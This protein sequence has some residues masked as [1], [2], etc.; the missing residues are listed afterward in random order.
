MTACEKCN[1]EC[2]RYVSVTLANPKGPEDWDEMKWI[3]LHN[4]VMIYKDYE[5]EFVFQ[6]VAVEK[7]PE[8]DFSEYG[9]LKV[10][11]SK[12]KK[13]KKKKKK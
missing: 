13:K 7:Q 11:K 5:D 10:V 3:L 1:A 4:N 12:K 6:K 9:D 8:P 2:C